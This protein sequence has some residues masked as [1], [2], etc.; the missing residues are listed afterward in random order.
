MSPITR[1]FLSE[2]T[3]GSYINVVVSGTPGVLLHTA[4]STVGEKD[5]VWLWGTNNTG[6]TASLI[7]EW[8]GTDGNTD[9][10]QVGIPSAQGRQLLIAGET[11]AGGLNVRAFST[12]PSAS[13]SGVN[14][15][16]HVNRIS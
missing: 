8:A 10:N 13:V 7:I 11:I 9:I 16:G 1:E 4:T 14:I 15:G 6:V 3:D 5:E 12:H 2:S